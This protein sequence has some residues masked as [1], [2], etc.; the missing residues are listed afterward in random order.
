MNNDL[1]KCMSEKHFNTA[2]E[3]AKRQ[4]IHDTASQG[5]LWAAEH[6]QQLENLLR[7]ADHFMLDDGEW[8]RERHALL[9]EN[10]NAT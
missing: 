6:I 5:L 7:K 1:D 4:H 8:L 9:K 3:S 10:D 2:V